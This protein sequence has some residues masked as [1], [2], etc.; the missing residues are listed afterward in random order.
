[1]AQRTR[2]AIGLGS[3]LGDRRARLDDAVRWLS[4][5]VAVVA[6]SE[7]VET[8]PVG[9]PPQGRFLNAAAVIE[10]DLSP[11]ELLAL[12]A[13]LE[14]RAGRERGERFGPRT[15]D[16]DILLYGAEQVRD[17]E[18]TVPHPRLHER[19][20]VLEPL[21]AVA[22]DWTVPGLDRNVGELLADLPDGR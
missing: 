11:H 3:N 2:A 16:V 5:R 1:M 21:A 18:L 8:D 9:G 22:G 10:T 12:A 17:P 14:A 7:P 19:R 20:F 6:V 13:E 4:E 15:L